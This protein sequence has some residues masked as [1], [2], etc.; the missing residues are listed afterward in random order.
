MKQ[1][2]VSSLPANARQATQD[3]PVASH[4]RA[5]APERALGPPVRWSQRAQQEL[6]VTVSGELPSWLRGQLVRTAPAAFSYGGVAVEHWFDAHALI[7]AFTLGQ[8]VHFRQQLLATQHRAELARGR[9]G[10][11]SFGTNMQRS[12]LRRLFQPIPPFTDNANVNVVPWQGQWLAMTESPHQHVIDRA[13]L[14]S[15]GLYRYD[16][17]L[18]GSMAMSAHPHYE[19]ASSSLVNVGTTFGAK[20]ALVVF[21]QH[22]S[23]RRREVEG[24]LPVKR[25]PYVH[26]FGLTPRSAVLIDQPLSVNPLRMLFSDKAYIRHFVWQPERGT[27][28]WKLDRRSGAFT[29]YETDALF[30]FHIAN[31]F[32]DGDDVVL[33][34]CA[35][36]DPGIVD[37]L[38]VDALARTKPAVMPRFVRARLS[39]GKTRAELEPLSDVRFDFPQIAYRARQGQPYRFVWGAA[40]APAGAGWSSVLHKVDTHTGDARTYADPTFTYGEPVFVARPGAEAED[41]GVLLTIGSHVHDECSRLLVL[42]AVTLEPLARCDAALS[43]PLGFH[44][45]FALQE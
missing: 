30:C 23:G 42:D 28:L 24:R 39:P 31:A 41:E 29:A 1:A 32:E 34:F 12:F 22:K 38:Y 25:V 13:T 4:T 21:R 19:S 43:I 7:Y 6:P 40:L 26:A 10:V 15:S 36:D 20:S 8:G 27:R 11:A 33:D 44:G 14:A 17:E 9:N 18:P 16:D 2:T 3:A 45:N 37:A 5:S 35:F